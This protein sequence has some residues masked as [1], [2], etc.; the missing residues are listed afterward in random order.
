MLPA[1][2]VVFDHLEQIRALVEV[3]AARKTTANWALG[4]R[5]ATFKMHPGLI[6]PP[7]FLVVARDWMYLWTS[8]NRGLPPDQ[9]YPTAEVLAPYFDDAQ[10]TAETIPPSALE[11]MVGI[12]LI[13]L[14]NGIKRAFAPSLGTSSLVDAV[15]AGRVEFPSAA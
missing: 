15:A 1:D 8:T 6:A 2:I 11:L 12:W 10:S 7:Y 14:A 5:E 9:Q 13:E 3:K 4:V